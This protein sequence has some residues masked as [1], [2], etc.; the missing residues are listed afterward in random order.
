VDEAHFVDELALE[1]L[2]ADD[3]CGRG[4]IS[5]IEKIWDELVIE[6]HGMHELPQ[7]RVYSTAAALMH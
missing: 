4:G 3:I 5:T 6:K 7:Q 2:L 1:L